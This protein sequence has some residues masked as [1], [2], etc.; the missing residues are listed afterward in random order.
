MIDVGLYTTLIGPGDIELDHGDTL[1]VSWEVDAGWTWSAQVAPASGYDPAHDV[2]STYQ[3]TL[4]DGLGNTLV[5][6][7]MVALQ[8]TIPDEDSAELSDTISLS[9]VDE[10][11]YRMGL[12]NQNFPSYKASS[13]ATIVGALA[14]RAGVTVNGMLDWYV[15]EEELK[16]TLLSEALSRFLEAAAYDHVVN[17]DGEIDCTAWEHDAG[18]LTFDWSNRTRTLD[19]QAKV[20][21]R[22]L[23]KRSSI[24]PGGEQ[25]Y[26][27][28]NAG[29]H[30]VALSAPL[31][32]PGASEATALGGLGAAIFFD[33]DPST[34]GILPPPYGFYVWDTDYTVNPP[35][36]GESPATHLRVVLNELSGGLTEYPIPLRV[37]VV[38]TPYAEEGLP[39]GVD[40]EFLYPEP[41]GD[42]DTS[43]GAR[44]SDN[45]FIDSVFPG[46]AW[47]AARYTHILNKMNSVTDRLSEDGQMNVGVRPLKRRTVGG[48]TYKVW[49]INHSLSSGQTSLEFVRTS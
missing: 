43:L 26:E 24:P 23:G 42:P 38:G 41:S 27:F 40:L 25:F 12:R 45:D 35:Y 47:A 2:G 5:C 4:V 28:T 46:Q 10:A 7:P 21:G 9:G 44:P 13:S 32:M 29:I 33:A 16:G 15:G 17:L 31:I 18:T 14:T 39:P 37:R 48:V 3:L 8:V 30:D 22:R 6:P 1:E 34:G 11:T 20:T 19:K 49:S 36:L